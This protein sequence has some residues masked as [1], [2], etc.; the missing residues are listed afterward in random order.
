M[1]REDFSRPALRRRRVIAV[2]E[3]KL[4]FEGRQLHA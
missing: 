3:T 4:E 1:L 2:D